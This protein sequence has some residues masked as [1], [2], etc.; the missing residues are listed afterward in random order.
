MVVACHQRMFDHSVFLHDNLPPVLPRVAE[1]AELCSAW[2]F[3]ALVDEKEARSF[4]RRTSHRC[5]TLQISSKKLETRL[6][7]DQDQAPVD[8]HTIKRPMRCAILSARRAFRSKRV[9]RLMVVA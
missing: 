7:S 2:Q 8:S 5:M 1:R 6:R 4:R 9:L 3:F